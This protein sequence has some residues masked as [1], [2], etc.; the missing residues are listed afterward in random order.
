M[1]PARKSHLLVVLSVVCVLQAETITV[2]KTTSAQYS[3]IQAA[4][5]AAQAGDTVKILDTE[6][7]EEQVTIDSTKQG[8][9]LRSADPLDS[10][11]PVIK[12][13]DRKNTDDAYDKNGALR[14]L[15]VRDVTIEGICIDGNGS[16][17]FKYYSPIQH[18]YLT[19]GNSAVCLSSSGNV[20]VR[21]C[22]VKN[23]F[24]GFYVTDKNLGGVSFSS[25]NCIDPPLPPP[26]NSEDFGIAG[27]HCIEYC[28]IHSNSLGFFFDSNYDLAST[29]RYNLIYDNYHFEQTREKLA[30]IEAAIPGGAFL[31]QER[32]ISPLVIHNNT[33]WRN[34]KTFV[35]LMRAGN[36]HLVFNNIYGRPKYYWREGYPGGE[37]YSGNWNVMDPYAFEYRMK[38]CVYAAQTEKPAP[39]AADVYSESCDN[40]IVINYYDTVNIMKDMGNPQTTDWDYPVKCPDGTVEYVHLNRVILPGA[41]ITGSS[42]TNSFPQEA[43]I[44][45]LETDDLF[46][47]TDPSDP[48]FLH[49]RWEDSLVIEYIKNKGWP[50]AG[51]TNND[52]KIADLG[53]ISSDGRN[54]PVLPLVSIKY[55]ETIDVNNTS[56]TARFRVDV[57]GGTFSNPRIR[58]LK[59]VKNVPGRSPSLAQTDI[60]ELDI[61]AKPVVTGNNVIEFEI[62]YYEEE[63]YAFLE[64]VLEGESS[65]GT[66]V[67]SS[68]GIIP[69]RKITHPFEVSL[70]KDGRDITTFTAGET[71]QLVVTPIENQQVFTHELD[72]FTIWHDH[73]WVVLYDA[74]TGEPLTSPVI[75]GRTVIDVFCT[76]ASEYTIFVAGQYKQLYF[77][78][79]SDEFRVLPGNAEKIVFKRPTPKVEGLR[80]PWIRSTESLPVEV[81][82]MDKYDNPVRKPSPVTIKSLDIGIGGF[83]VGESVMES[84]TVQ[85]DSFGIARCSA[86]VTN[87]HQGDIFNMEATLEEGGKPASLADLMVARVSQIELFCEDSSER[88]LVFPINKRIPLTLSATEGS[89]SINRELTISAANDNISLFA[90]QEA[91]E[92][93][94]DFHLT[95][96]EV[97]FWVYSSDTV[98]NAHLRISYST[99]IYP[100][101]EDIYI[102]TFKATTPVP[103]REQNFPKKLSYTC[104]VYDLKGRIV[105]RVESRSRRLDQKILKRRVPAGIYMVKT[106]LEGKV[107]QTRRRLVGR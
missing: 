62:P 98:S 60:V 88:N 38:H 24:F 32:M 85:T 46:V 87:G 4:V 6:I 21:N 34:Y 33:F 63:E 12:W 70:Q 104:V 18:K 41:L 106:E 75:K 74:A 58:Y 37:L 71:V 96:G 100:S 94:T 16:Y 66:T 91:S 76:R 15:N 10:R 49:P 45:W 81:L 42:E 83:K 17:P 89:S 68:V 55:S 53:A 101:N 50:E 7:Y 90:S 40:G 11:K 39:I 67:T 51:I 105:G 56:G 82:V 93:Q 30:I 78:S 14:L 97:R 8:I 26:T 72:T 47:T 86:V 57:S 19:H 52:G 65:D 69:Y 36:Q 48:Q 77:G 102:L 9:A 107:V 2:S 84:V 99:D 54:G 35:G 27:G 92:P 103:L 31:I 64:M 28:K 29:V 59:W 73:P 61:P 1:K 13:Q 44:R 23:S 20:I 22:E 79:L 25:G 3:S 43:N 5:N 80:P 95:D